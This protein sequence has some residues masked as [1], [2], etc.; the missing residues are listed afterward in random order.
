M[1]R[2]G[3]GGTRG[4]TCMGSRHHIRTQQ[5]PP[6]GIG[7]GACKPH[8]HTGSRSVTW[9]GAGG[10]LHLSWCLLAVPTLR[11]DQSCGVHRARRA[12]K[13]SDWPAP[14]RACARSP[15]TR[16]HARRASPA[17]SRPRGSLTSAS[18]QTWRT[19]AAA[20]AA[21]AATPAAALEAS[22]PVALRGEAA[23]QLASPAVGPPPT[24]LIPG[25]PCHAG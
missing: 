24:T 16:M 19:P 20:A 22:A 9:R 18:A 15:C 6:V 12:P 14:S 23:A 25:P 2:H 5:R 7:N 13:T 11:W 3:A 8:C 21:A 4:V 10:A 1:Y 17:P